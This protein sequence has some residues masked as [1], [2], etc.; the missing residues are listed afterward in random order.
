VTVERDQL[1]LIVILEMIAHIKR[2]LEDFS[3]ARFATDRDEIDL[4]AFRLQV[5]GEEIHKLSEE[6]K[7]ANPQIDWLRAYNLRNLVAHDYGA[8]RPERIWAVIENDLI[9]LV[10]VARLE[11]A[12]FE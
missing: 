3:A 1:H 4:T 6:L 8:V 10:H 12:K 7:A 2:R 9:S 5:I 11:L